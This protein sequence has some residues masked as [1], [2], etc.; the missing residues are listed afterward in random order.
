M[1]VLTLRYLSRRAELAF[2]LILRAHPRKI[3]YRPRQ[4]PLKAPGNE[5][6]PTRTLIDDPFNAEIIHLER[7]SPSIDGFQLYTVDGFSLEDRERRFFGNHN[8]LLYDLCPFVIVE[9]EDVIRAGG[10]K[11]GEIA[12]R[13]WQHEPEP[14]VIVNDDDPGGFVEM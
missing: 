6:T 8:V 2:E 1:V 7:A 5:G 14:G 4:V 13:K 11:D 12:P 10:G 9:H 3:E